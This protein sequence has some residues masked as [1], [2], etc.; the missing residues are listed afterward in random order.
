MY[1]DGNDDNFVISWNTAMGYPDQTVKMM[2]RLDNQVGNYL[3]RQSVSRDGG[4]LTSTTGLPKGGL[5]IVWLR[6]ETA[7][8]YGDWQ[9][10]T[11]ITDN[12]WNSDSDTV[13]HLGETVFHGEDVVLYS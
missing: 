7:T 2:A 9:F 8:T 6:P 4:A 11:A 13:V 5:Y 1:I 10:V 3:P 12:G